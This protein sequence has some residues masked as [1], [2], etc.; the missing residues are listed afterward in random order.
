MSRR[1]HDGFFK[2]C[3]AMLESHESL[4][5]RSISSF[6]EVA[7]S[8]LQDGLKRVDNCIIN[9]DDYEEQLVPL[10]KWYFDTSGNTI[11]SYLTQ[12]EL[13]D[14]YHFGKKLLIMNPK[15]IKMN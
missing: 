4:S 1:Y 2:L 13:I 6:L 11:S 7:R 14:L 3:A 15:I 9:E 5:V 12:Q 8:T 10:L